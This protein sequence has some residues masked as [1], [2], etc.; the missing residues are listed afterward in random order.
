MGPGSGAVTALLGSKK[1]LLDS[2]TALH[3]SG[4]ALTCLCIEKGL[5]KKKR[6]C[7]VL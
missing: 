4:K 2:G 6:H 5:Q 1:E 3:D 7:F